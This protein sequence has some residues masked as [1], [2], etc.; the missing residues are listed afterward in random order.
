MPE[1]TLER[2]GL[3]RPFSGAAEADHI[4]L[5]GSR[6]RG[7][8][9]TKSY[10][11]AELWIQEGGARNLAP[12]MAAIAMA[13][14]GGD[15][16]TPPNQNADGSV[17]YGL[18]RI[19]SSHTQFDPVRLQNDPAYNARAAVIVERSQGLDAWT[20]YRTG[21]YRPFLGTP[22]TYSGPTFTRTRP[23]GGGDD[24]SSVDTIFASYE[25]DAQD[26]SLFNFNPLAPFLGPLEGLLGIKPAP[27]TTIPLPDPLKTFS[28][29]AKAIKTT[30]D[31]LGAIAWLF[32]P[33]NILRVVE[34]TIG[35]TLMAAGFHAMIE[36]YR[37]S[38]EQAAPRRAGRRLRT[39]AGEAF[40]M[41]PPGRALRVRKAAS[42]GKRRARSKVRAQESQAAAKRA[43]Q[44][45]A[46]RQ[47]KARNKREAKA[48]RRRGE[49][50]PF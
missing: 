1:P 11:L 48:D 5:L 27:G 29:A 16:S 25:Q 21:A 32:I 17:D 7:R 20:T 2:F 22:D 4:Q 39:A 28:D 12:L 9:R 23:G 45:E 46:K 13:E 35:L 15:L 37:N 36:V 31:F 3:T 8:T 42:F 18:W 33:R 6:T 40:S 41:T 49:D 19:N 43:Q 47:G 10:S 26:A 50:I 38:P 24:G 44:R 30:S 34:V 14:S